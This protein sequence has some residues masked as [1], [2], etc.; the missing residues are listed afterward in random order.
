ML[1]RPRDDARRSRQPA[2]RSEDGE[3]DGLGAGRRERDL[4]TLG[5]QLFGH[6]VAGAIESGPRGAALGMEARGVG[7]RLVAQRFHDLAQDRRG[8]GVVEIDALDRGGG[9]RRASRGQD[10]PRLWSGWCSR[11]LS[12][13]W[14]LFKYRWTSRISS[15]VIGSSSGSAALTSAVRAAAI[16]LVSTLSISSTA[17]PAIASTT[18]NVTWHCAHVTWM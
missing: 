16:A 11:S 10:Q 14:K 6:Q 17:P 9:T 3:V 1:G 4:R 15:T 7:R 18:M 5:V 8:A 2:G 13:P 12:V